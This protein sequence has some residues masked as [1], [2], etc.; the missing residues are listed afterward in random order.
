MEYVVLAQTLAKHNITI[1][2]NN[3]ITRKILLQNGFDPRNVRFNKKTSHAMY[4]NFWIDITA[5]FHLLIYP[6]RKA[7]TVDGE[8]MWKFTHSLIEYWYVWPVALQK[9]FS[10]DDFNEFLALLPAAIIKEID[11]ILQH[12]TPSTTN[13]HY[14]DGFV[15]QRKQI[16]DELLRVGLKVMFV[17]WEKNNMSAL[18]LLNKYP[19]HVAFICCD[20]TKEEFMSAINVNG[21][22]EICCNVSANTLTWQVTSSRMDIDFANNMDL[23]TLIEMIPKI[24]DCIVQTIKN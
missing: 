2:V 12:V 13:Q 11:Y 22:L 21:I 3:D 18:K 10:I 8:I 14:Y 23:A 1:T 9:L 24:H 16:I 7:A 15:L 19:K 20:E 4:P 6:F 5:K 17:C